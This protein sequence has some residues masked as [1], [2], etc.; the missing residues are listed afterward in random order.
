M[1]TDKKKKKAV[2]KSEHMESGSNWAALRQ[3]LKPADI[4][5]TVTVRTSHSLHPTP[6]HQRFT[7]ISKVQLSLSHAAHRS[8]HAQEK[9]TWNLSG[10]Y[11]SRQNLC[12]HEFYLMYVFYLSVQCNCL[13]VTPTW[14]HSLTDRPPLIRVILVFYASNEQY[15]NCDCHLILDQHCV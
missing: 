11:T 7:L 5:C 10:F 14:L 2:V 1:A 13:L 4:W 12:E 3:A 6:Q 9:R 8:H 15:L